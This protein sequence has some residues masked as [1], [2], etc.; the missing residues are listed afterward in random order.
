M[1]G[2]SAAD[3][4]T[5]VVI[6]IDKLLKPVS[7]DNPVGEDLRRMMAPGGKSIFMDDIEERRRAVIS[8]VNENMEAG[9]QSDPAMLM[10][11]RRGEWRD[12][13]RLVTGAF[14]KG[15]ELG[16]AVTLVLA[17]V[18]GRGWAAMAPGFQF[19]RRL[20]EEYFEPLHPV[21]DVDDSGNPD[22]VDRLVLLER[23]DHDSFLPLAIRQLGLTDAKSGGEYSWADFKQ[24][25]ILKGSKPGENEDPETHRANI[26]ERT[27]VIEEAADRS[28][29]AFY[30]KLIEN[31]DSASQELAA[32]RDFINDRYSAAPEDERPNFGKIEATIEEARA[33]ASRY[34][35][36][37]GG[38]AQEAAEA[39]D[40]GGGAS[41]EGGIGMGGVGIPAGADVVTLLE[42]AL[43]VLRTHQR[44]NPAA[45]LVEEAI[46]WTKMPISA[47]YLEA[48]QDPNMSGFI[49]RLM[50]NAASGS[51][52]APEE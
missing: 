52:P 1:K 34:W 23:L 39:G 45:F 48:V 19:L 42:R 47:W 38:G 10:Q 20:Q 6:D 35:K 14:A 31:I 44:H 25:E 11:Q 29:L 51:A 37:K 4:S 12:I 49:S 26:A 24:L 21:V 32:L 30:T 33:I 13:E 17:A 22:Y 18:S 15:K 36:K 41:A 28:S 2:M 7:D 50:G 3:S 8:G 46:R 40:E 27:R 43:A 16:A 9:Q 5:P